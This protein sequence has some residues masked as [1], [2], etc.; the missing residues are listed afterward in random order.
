MCDDFVAE[1]FV[2]SFRCCRVF[3]FIESYDL[4]D[5]VKKILEKLLL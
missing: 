1:I 5:T 4:N 3:S 2:A